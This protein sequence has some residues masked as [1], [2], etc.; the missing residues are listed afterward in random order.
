MV[1]CFENFVHGVFYVEKHKNQ[2]MTEVWYDISIYDLKPYDPHSEDYSNPYH[3][4]DISNVYISMYHEK[5]Y[6]LLFRNLTI[7][8]G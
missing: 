1:D 8:Y 6:W 5:Y 4:H 7:I 2:L 3:C